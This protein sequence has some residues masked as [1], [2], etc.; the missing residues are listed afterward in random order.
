MGIDLIVYH[1]LI[2]ASIVYNSHTWLVQVWTPIFHNQIP[3]WSD[4]QYFFTH[5]MS[6][7]STLA[8]STHVR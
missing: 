8:I 2:L 4:N 3:N 1:I 5:T 7:H 6:Y